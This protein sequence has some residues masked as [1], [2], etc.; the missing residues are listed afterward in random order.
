VTRWAV[1]S[2]NS[3]KKKQREMVD[4]I[5]KKALDPTGNTLAP[6]F[7]EELQQ[8]HRHPGAQTALT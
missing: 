8:H 4:D 7:L 3:T 5:K 2:G 6:K 1:S